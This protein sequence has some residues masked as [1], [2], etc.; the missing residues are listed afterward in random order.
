VLP[1]LDLRLLA[2]ASLAQMAV[3]LGLVFVMIRSAEA[4]AVVGPLHG[5]PL[6]RE[7]LDT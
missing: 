7:I 4:R 5:P 2:I 3:T 1:R 6:N